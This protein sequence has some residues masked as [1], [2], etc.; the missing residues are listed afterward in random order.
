L[1]HRVAIPLSAAFLVWTGL[2][3]SAGA[4]G[5]AVRTTTGG[6]VHLIAPLGGRWDGTAREVVRR[7]RCSARRARP[8]SLRRRLQGGRGHGAGLRRRADIS[9]QV[10]SLKGMTLSTATT[11]E[12]RESLTTIGNDL[13]KIKDAQ[14]ELDGQRKSQVQQANQAFESQLKSIRSTLGSTT[15]L[16]DAEAQLSQAFQQLA[17][18]YEDT[19]SKIDCG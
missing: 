6:R 14:G 16:S 19:F 15:S 8:W 5:G 7:D 13:T 18:A 17:S 9:K 4:A 11:S 1:R 3:R 10:D 2:E 12:I